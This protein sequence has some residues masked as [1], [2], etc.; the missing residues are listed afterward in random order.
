MSDAFFDH[1][2]GRSDVVPPGHTE[3]GMRAYRH[4]VYLGASQMIEAH[5]PDVRQELGE[6]GW[7]TL[8]EDF[9]RQSAWTSPFYGDLK[10]EFI[11]YLARQSA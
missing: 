8:I 11:A 3:R 5:F 4:L 2:R 9:V 10:D 7:R 6:D 1:V